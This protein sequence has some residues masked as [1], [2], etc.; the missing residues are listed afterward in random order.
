[1]SEERIKVL[2]EQVAILFKQNKKMLEHIREF[3]EILAEQ[4][5]EASEKE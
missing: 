3:S 1:M 2:E 4:I 5:R